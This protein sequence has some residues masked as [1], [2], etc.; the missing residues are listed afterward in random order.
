M[1]V[2]AF[3]SQSRVLIVAGKGGVGKTTVTAALAKMA[4]A[5]GLDV[6]VVELEGKAGVPTAFGREG[7]L[8]YDETVL[9]RPAG[10]GSVRA[11]RITPDDALVEYL[12]DHGMGRISKRLVSSG[13]LDVVATAIPG[14]G[15]ILVL[16]KVRQIES[17]DWSD[18]IL[19]DAP[20]AGHAVTFLSSAKGLVDA[21]RSGPVRAQAAEVVEFL[22]D[23][24]RCQ[25][26]LVTLP[27]EMPVTEVVETAYQLE[28][29]VGVTLGPVIV[30][31]CLPEEPL[32]DTDP[33]QAAEQAGVDIDDALASAIGRAAGFHQ[34]R[35]GL[36][37]EQLE[38]LARELPLPQLHAPFLF[39]SC[40]G[41]NELES[42][43]TRLAREVGRL[44]DEHGK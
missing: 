17:H 6:L 30:N 37:A 21:A 27:E 12:A 14:I 15:D 22:S 11:R 35:Y 36:Q 3:C 4:S 7:S 19:V 23:A 25:V 1:D 42:I 8:D 18:V 26:L 29:R 2:A 44:Q 28:D 38:R 5:S 13:A 10:A 33:T 32:L 31:A 24:E 20:A 41:P 16:G 39:G 40:I 9:S 34:N 43:G